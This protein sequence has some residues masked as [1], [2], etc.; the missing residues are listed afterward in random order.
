MDED[1]A[2]DVL[3]FFKEKPTLL[4]KRIAHADPILMRIMDD[5]GEV[6]TG[7]AIRIYSTRH[8][9]RAPYS[10]ETLQV[11]K[12]SSAW[13]N[14]TLGQSGTTA[15]AFIA[16]SERDDHYRE[17]PWRGHFAVEDI[18]GM[19]CAV[20]HYHLLNEKECGLWEPSYL[21]EAA[22]LPDT[23]RPGRVAIPYPLL[24]RHLLDELALMENA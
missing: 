17:Y 22:F 5:D 13:G 8:A 12:A 3:D 1:T 24:E 20:A 15:L 18:A 9:G 7:R 14:V 10:A 23:S 6:V 16:G 2:E 19:V 21:R 11:R 4:R